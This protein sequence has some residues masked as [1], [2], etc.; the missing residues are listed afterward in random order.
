MQG[1]ASAKVLRARQSGALRGR[2]TI[3]G[4]KSIS[5]R[6]LILGALAVGETRVEG[7]LEA[8]DVL[9]T[10]AAM[11]ALGAEVTSDGAGAWRI[12]GRGVGGLSEPQ[13]VMDFGNSGTGSR[14]VMGAIATTPMMA[15]FTGDASLRRRPMG[16]V[17]KP[18]AA[19]GTEYFA[20]DDEFMPVAVRGAERPLAIECE[21]TVPSAQVKSALLL[22]A[23]NAPGR[24]RITQRERTRDH[25]EKMLS[26]FGAKLS[27]EA[28]KEGEAIEIEGE[29][30]LRPA[31]ISVPAD[32]S[33]AAFAIV[34]A[35]IVPG[36]DVVIPSVLLNS[37]RAGLI[38]VLMEMGAN[39]IVENRRESG[40]EPIGDLKVRHAPLRSVDVAPE[41]APSM[42][43][44]YPVL[45]IAAA[46]AEGRSKMSGLEE[47]IVKET[48][49]LAATVN[50]L[51]ACGV[52]AEA[53]DGQMVVEGC[54]ALGVPGGAR[55][56]AQMDHRIAMSFLTLGLASRDPVSI[57]DASMIGTSF[58]SFESLMR[59][60]GADL[61]VPNA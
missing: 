30:E 60:L 57:D 54:G 6:A 45:A 9:R 23:L 25:T 59:D 26:A 16:R 29:N 41:R 61:S 38:E 35:T 14:L 32:P 3:P 27:V 42:I 31:S 52:R 37:R 40:G 10:A 47:L 21:V 36:S 15:V 1:Q 5:H 53:K 39:I 58:P 34:A 43:D 17:L 2:A 48:D 33:S 44:E 50:G 46:F 24:T 11:R 49:R 19:F 12:Y 55:V 56:A 20:R 13:D 18:L 22:A 28:L 7:L 51:R 8:D 4:D